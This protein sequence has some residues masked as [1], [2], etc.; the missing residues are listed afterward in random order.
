MAIVRTIRKK[1]RKS[2]LIQKEPSEEK[3]QQAIKKD[4]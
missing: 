4:V 2:K 1:P 3:S